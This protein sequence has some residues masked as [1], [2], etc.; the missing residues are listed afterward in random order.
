MAFGLS[1]T[2]MGPAKDGGRQGAAHDAQ[3]VAASASRQNHAARRW[4]SGLL[5]H[6]T[7]ANVTNTKRDHTVNHYGSCDLCEKK[8]AS[9]RYVARAFFA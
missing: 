5:I 6:S 8:P 7:R 2:Q 3:A 4:H 9:V 1:L